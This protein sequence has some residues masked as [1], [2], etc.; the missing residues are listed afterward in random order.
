MATDTHK[1]RDEKKDDEAAAKGATGPE[2]TCAES[3][4]E[5]FAKA[6]GMSTMA[7]AMAKCCR[8]F[9]AKDPQSPAGTETDEAPAGTKPATSSTKEV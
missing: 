2:G 9:A 7:D 5:H 1:L 8:A 6:G 4:A 3:M